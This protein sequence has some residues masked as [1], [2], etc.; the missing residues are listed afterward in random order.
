M[1]PENEL[2]LELTSNI[3]GYAPGPVRELPEMMLPDTAMFS[4]EFIQMPATELL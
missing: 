2:R 4:Q 1:F 3:P